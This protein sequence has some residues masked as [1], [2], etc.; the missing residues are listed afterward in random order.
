MGHG[1]LQT[2]TV[3]WR[4]LGAPASFRPDSQRAPQ[5]GQEEVACG[6]R[7]VLGFIC[8]RRGWEPRSSDQ[9]PTPRTKKGRTTYLEEPRFPFACGTAGKVSRHLP[10]GRLPSGTPSISCQGTVCS[11]HT[12]CCA[13]AYFS[14]ARSESNPAKLRAGP[15]DIGM[16]ARTAFPRQTLCSQP[17]S[18]NMRK[19][20]RR[21]SAD[22][23][24]IHMH[25]AEGP[26]S[27]AELR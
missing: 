21:L 9:I 23:C 16:R 11:L 24:C 13:R 17:E 14:W 18:I 22:H 3:G 15:G 1:S 19:K 12:G 8:P 4:C 25:E 20:N 10:D 2:L 6:S 26:N 5:P 7:C 27:L